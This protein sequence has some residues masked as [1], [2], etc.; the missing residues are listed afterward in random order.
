MARKTSK[1][2]VN[3]VGSKQLSLVRDTEE[4]ARELGFK[5]V[6]DDDYSY[7]MTLYPTRGLS[8]TMFGKNTII[9]RYDE[10]RDIKCWLQGWKKLE[11][12]LLD[13]T[14]LTVQDI[15]DSMNQREILNKLQ[16]T[17]EDE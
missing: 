7:K 9:V 5:I 11:S 4:L 3:P 17:P 8:L 13:K 15:R 6:I 12:V 1:D 10:I 2:I 16:K 14:L